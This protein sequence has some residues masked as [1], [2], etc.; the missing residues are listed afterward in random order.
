MANNKG[1]P[2]GAR[3]P[4]SEFR[5]FG[6]AHPAS[7]QNE[8]TVPVSRKRRVMV[9]LFTVGWMRKAAV[10]VGRGSDAPWNG[11]MQRQGCRPPG[12]Q[13]PGGREISSLKADAAK[14]AERL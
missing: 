7:A 11:K 10:R 14:Y 6:R 8:S 5:G 2:A 4:A 9:G 3:T 13:A 1:P 12:R